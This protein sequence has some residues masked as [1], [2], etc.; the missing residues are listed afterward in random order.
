MA[1]P[2]WLVLGALT[3]ERTG[4]AVARAASDAFTALGAQVPA[5]S[6][7]GYGDIGS[8]GAVVNESVSLTGD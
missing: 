5:Y 8:R 6:G 3:A 2:A 1:R 4:A 7:I